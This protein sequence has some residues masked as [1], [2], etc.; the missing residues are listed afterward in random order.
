MIRVSVDGEE[1]V[2]FERFDQLWAWARERARLEP[3]PDA[4]TGMLPPSAELTRETE[5]AA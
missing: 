4:V 3:D 2:E 1:G 5:K